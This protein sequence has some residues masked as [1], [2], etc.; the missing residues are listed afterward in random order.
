MILSKLGSD[1]TLLPVSRDLAYIIITNNHSSKIT[2]HGDFIFE[3]SF[4]TI[5]IMIGIGSLR[6][7]VCWRVDA[8]GRGRERTGRLFKTPL[9][10]MQINIYMY[11]HCLKMKNKLKWHQLILYLGLDDL[12][13]E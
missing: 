4:N 6:A 12:I 3:M 5:L 2:D 7:G 9:F 1:E 11:T 8:G 13:P 10:C